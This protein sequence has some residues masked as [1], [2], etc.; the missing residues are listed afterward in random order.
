MK[1]KI[2][3]LNEHLLRHNGMIT[4]ITEE[5]INVKRTRESPSKSLFN[6]IFHRMGFI[7]YQQ[8]KTYATDMNGYNDMTRSLEADV[9]ESYFNNNTAP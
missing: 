9:D 8:L 5:K 6:E 4:I 1:S 3:K 7:F 2:I